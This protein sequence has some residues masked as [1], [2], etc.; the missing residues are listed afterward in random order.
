MA[1][2]TVQDWIVEL[3]Y[4]DSKVVKGVKNTEKVLGKLDKIKSKTSSKATANIS[5]EN[6]ALRKQNILESQRLQ[7]R[8]KINQAEQ[9]G[10]KDLKR[11]RGALGGTNPVRIRQKVLE[12]DKRITI[13]RKKQSEIASK[14]KAEASV[15]RPGRKPFEMTSS[16]K[17]DM[18]FSI[19]SVMRRAKAG[20]GETS[21]E[22]QRL[23]RQAAIL[24]R[25]I[26]EV[27]SRDDLSRLRNDMR[28]LREQ[29]TS[30]TSALRSQKRVMTKQQFAASRL[31]NSIRNLAGAYISIF[32]AMQGAGAFFR[33]GEEL[34]SL[35][36]SLL[37]ASGS[38]EQAGKDFK[39]VQTQSQRLGFS[40]IETAKGWKQIGAAGRASNL[41]MEET[42]EIWLAGSEAARAFGLNS[43]RLGHVHL[44]LSQIISKGRVSM[45]EL[46]RQLGEHLP[47]AMSIGARAMGVNTQEFEKMVEA[48]ISAEEFM[49]KFAKELRRTVRESGALAES[50]KKISAEKGRLRN[51]LEL[52]IKESF[53]GGAREGTIDFLQG[54]TRLVK[55][56]TPAFKVL[57]VAVKVI[58]GV[59]KIIFNL[60]SDIVRAISSTL[61][62]VG[63][64]VIGLFD[65]AE[66]LGS[67]NSEMKKM[68]DESKEQLT[69]L[70]RF[71]NFWDKI[72]KKVVKLWGTIKLIGLLIKESASF[73]FEGKKKSDKKLAIVDKILADPLIMETI[74]SEEARKQESEFRKRQKQSLRKVF[75]ESPKVENKVDV[76]I[77]GVDTNNTEAVK[78]VVREEIPKEMQKQLV[79]GSSGTV[80]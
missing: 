73:S 58:G 32:A 57:G 41:T 31:S 78:R 66:A 80:F 43:Q 28:L 6:Q 20:L 5:K 11:E 12:L 24:K 39:F 46:R 47:G 55:E 8:K 61:G 74:G 42:R 77:N 36:A 3:G 40:L 16:R 48:G 70:Q 2:S 15:K 22:F 59:L 68:N 50:L 35:N 14:Q 27:G 33:I 51:A 38:T 25:R 76:T 23:N 21:E 4:D 7:L 60:V 71:S 69:F 18:E 19:D 62:F 54:L 53:D 75:S 29:T 45:E 17:L 13:E 26:R 10:I 63:D 49:P 72:Q 65:G 79:I 34:D 67:M 56:L 37:A 9:I 52:G 30:A 1:S 44:A 64:I